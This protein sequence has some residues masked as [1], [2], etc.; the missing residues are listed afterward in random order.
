MMQ[1]S[2]HTNFKKDVNIEVGTLNN[3]TLG[4]FP[5]VRI[6]DEFTWFPSIEQMQDLHKKMGKFLAENVKLIGVEK[7]GL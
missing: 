2:L 3:E 6:A 1:G 4:N 7:N 5:T